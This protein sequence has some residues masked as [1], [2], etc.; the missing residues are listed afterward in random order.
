MADF[1]PKLILSTDGKPPMEDALLLDAGGAPVPASS[2]Q[3]LVGETV[4]RTVLAFDVG[5]GLATLWSGLVQRQWQ[6]S[7]EAVALFARFDA[8]PHAFARQNELM[9][10]AM[11]DTVDTALEALAVPIGQAAGQA[12]SSLGRA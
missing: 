2:E 10:E 12:I 4:Q 6:R 8:S 5:M 3:N 9:N 7:F 1:P 11:R